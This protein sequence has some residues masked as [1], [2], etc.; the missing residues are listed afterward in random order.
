M[1]SGNSTVMIN[2][3]LP[4]NVVHHELAFMREVAWDLDEIPITGTSNP[5]RLKFAVLSFF[6]RLHK[7][8]FHNFLT[9]QMMMNIRSNS[10]THPL[11]FHTADTCKLYLHNMITNAKGEVTSDD[12]RVEVLLP[13]TRLFCSRLSSPLLELPLRPRTCHAITMFT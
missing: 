3:L 2:E 1:P 7:N 13:L 12:Y 9:L 5:R 8:R 10:H 11:V 6:P 4:N